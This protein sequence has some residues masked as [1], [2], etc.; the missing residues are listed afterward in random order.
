MR[1]HLTLFAC[2]VLLFSFLPIARVAA[3]AKDSVRQVQITSLTASR[4]PTP[5]RE[6]AGRRL[7]H[8]FTSRGI[9]VTEKAEW[10]IWCEVSTAEGIDPEHVL[11][12]VGYGRVLPG[13]VM[14]LGKKAEAFYSYLPPEKKSMLP[15]EGKGVREYMSEEFLC[16]FVFPIDQ[17]IVV[18]P[19]RELSRHVDAM[20]QKIY[21]RWMGK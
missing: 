10:A 13:D 16:E 19:R 14:E 7:Y 20:V 1:V 9:V 5:L 15:P 17:E 4:P 18:V 12:A 3:A 21:D 2:F 6:E 8:W 11:L